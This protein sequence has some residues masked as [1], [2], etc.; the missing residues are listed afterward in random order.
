MRWTAGRRAA[1]RS[2]LAPIPNA[3]TSQ[4]FEQFEATRL[5]LSR[6]LFEITDE[7]ASFE[8]CPTRLQMLHR[9]FSREMSREVQHLAS[10]APL[11]PWT[12]PVR[13]NGLAGQSHAV[14]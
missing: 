13:E 9:E 1:F 6:R 11:S 12:V 4:A 3:G 10:L 14:M 2:H 8:P 7:I 5:E